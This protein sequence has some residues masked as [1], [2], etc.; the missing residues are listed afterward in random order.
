[1]KSLLITIFL[2]L[3]IK[4]PL[5]GFD[6]SEIDK[7]S[8][9][10]FTNYVKDV[11]LDASADPS[12][13]D[14]LILFQSHGPSKSL[15]LISKRKLNSK[16][17]L[18]GYTL[19]QLSFSSAILDY[20]KSIVSRRTPFRKIPYVLRQRFFS[21][22]EFQIFINSYITFVGELEWSKMSGYYFHI[23]SISLRSYLSSEYVF[24]KFSKDVNYFSLHLF[25]D[26]FRDVFIED[27]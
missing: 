1:M 11:R 25:N 13:G 15:F 4:I 5:S 18:E 19:Y 27:L 3:F 24:I 20:T 12:Q 14:N 6:F 22:H 26:F 23:H 9:L 8:I 21:V 10:S 7:R 2:L 16:G 17:F